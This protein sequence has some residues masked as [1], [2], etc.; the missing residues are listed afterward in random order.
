MRKQR[1][2]EIQATLFDEP[3]E[4][5]KTIRDVPHDY[6]I[7]KTAKDRA[8]LLDRV[9]GSERSLLRHRNDGPESA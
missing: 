8:A 7:V 9:D 3:V 4:E 1:E 5:E 2:T 6:Q